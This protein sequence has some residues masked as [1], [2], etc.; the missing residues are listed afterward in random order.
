M[1]LLMFSA[2]SAAKNPTQKTTSIN[3]RV[4][5]SGV[6][7]HNIAEQMMTTTENPAIHGSLRPEA[8]AQAPSSGAVKAMNRPEIVCPSDHRLCACASAAPESIP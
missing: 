5:P 1:A 8:S 4:D 6:S 3:I 2:D 7:P